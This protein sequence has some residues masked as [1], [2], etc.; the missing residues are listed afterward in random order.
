[1]LNQLAH[2]GFVGWHLEM[3]LDVPAP[4][5]ALEG[6]DGGFGRIQPLGQDVGE[7]FGGLLVADEAGDGG[8]SNVMHGLSHIADRTSALTP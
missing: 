5:E 3:D 4:V 7:A 6:R 1:L 2:R 8:I